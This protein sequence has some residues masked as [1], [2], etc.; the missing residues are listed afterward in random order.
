MSDSKS[1]RWISAQLRQVP[2]PEGLLERLRAV[3]QQSDGEL[4]ALLSDVAVPDGLVARLRE[5]VAA[6]E[7]ETSCHG[8]QF[9][10][11]PIPRA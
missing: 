3:A 2:L 10:L 8:P 7:L 4:D 9:L 11:C 6:E 1:D 5:I